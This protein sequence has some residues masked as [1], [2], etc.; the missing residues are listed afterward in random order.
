MYRKYKV[1][2]KVRVAISVKPRLI[3]IENELSCL[4]KSFGDVTY[5]FHRRANPLSSNSC[6]EQ[7]ASLVLKHCSTVC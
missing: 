6:V 2:P 4:Y 3:Y 7:M 5:H 1:R